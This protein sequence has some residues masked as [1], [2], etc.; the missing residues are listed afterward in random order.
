M[1]K[2]FTTFFAILLCVVASQAQW[3][4]TG[5]AGTDPA[6][7]FIGTTDTQALVFKT[8]S[9]QAGSID[10]KKYNASFGYQALYFFSSGTFN[11]A[12]GHQAMAFNT[13]GVQNTSVGSWALRD[14]TTGSAN[15]AV[16][17]GALVNS[18]TGHGNTAI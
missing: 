8:N 15:I 16:G 14:N 1:K 13:T 17:Y 5:N 12:F 18:E 3:S 6:I 7:N 2:K 9:I 4:L 11:A 10:Y